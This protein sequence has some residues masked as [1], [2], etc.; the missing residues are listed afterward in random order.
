MVCAKLEFKG[1]KT[2]FCFT[3]LGFDLIHLSSKKLLS[4]SFLLKACIFSWKPFY[5]LFSP[6]S[7]FYSTQN[8][9]SCF[10]SNFSFANSFFRLKIVTNTITGL[11]RNTPFTW[12][13]ICFLKPS[14]YLLQ[15]SQPFSSKRAFHVFAILTKVDTS[16][17]IALSIKWL[18]AFTAVLETY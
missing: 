16:L 12:F 17:P 13:L 9:P 8:S 14:P 10:L 2:F 3:F 11:L 6:L 1:Y 15:C 7:Q 4:N 5:Y 18:T